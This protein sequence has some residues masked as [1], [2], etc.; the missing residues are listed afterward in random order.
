MPRPKKELPNREDGLYEVKI[1]IGKDVFDRPIRKSFYSTKSKEDARQQ[2][3]DYLI[4]RT[5]ALE[6]ASESIDTV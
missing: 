5:V 1:T 6:T 3:S 4:Q 2:A